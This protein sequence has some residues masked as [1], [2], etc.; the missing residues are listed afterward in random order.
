[1]LGLINECKYVNNVNTLMY[2]IHT[3]MNVNTSHNVSK[4]KAQRE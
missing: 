2:I 4:I 1:M 3:L